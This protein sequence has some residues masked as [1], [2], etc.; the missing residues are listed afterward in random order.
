M[1]GILI[2]AVPEFYGTRFWH[3]GSNACHGDDCT[4]VP[5][6]VSNLAIGRTSAGCFIAP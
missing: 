4:Q 5:D 2:V 1:P 3:D 6:R